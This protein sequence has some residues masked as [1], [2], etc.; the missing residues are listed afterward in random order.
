MIPT[1]LD[2]CGL[3]LCNL[4]LVSSAVAIGLVPAR[5]EVDLGPVPG[6]VQAVEAIVSTP[7]LN[8]E[9]LVL[10]DGDVIVDSQ[11]AMHTF[12]EDTVRVESGGFPV[13]RVAWEPCFESNVF[14]ILVHFDP[15]PTPTPAPAAVPLDRLLAQFDKPVFVHCGSGNR[16]GA[17]LA[18]RAKL[19]GADDETAIAAGRETGLKGLEEV[20]KE[21][22]QER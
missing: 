15:A 4:N 20:V 17:L 5:L 1:P 13:D 11:V 19:N 12:P 7:A 14:E 2:E 22:M 6:A 18:L 9:P 10:Y 8:S 16:A 3:E 21:R